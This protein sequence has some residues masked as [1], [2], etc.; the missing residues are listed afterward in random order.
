MKNWAYIVTILHSGR[1]GG[2][3][4]DCS[5]RRAEWIPAEQPAGT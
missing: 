4:T 2:C 1:N 5:V 3:F